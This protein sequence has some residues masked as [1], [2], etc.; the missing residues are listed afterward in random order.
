MSTFSLLRV[1]VGGSQEAASGVWS[2]LALLGSMTALCRHHGG[3]VTG[4]RE[5]GWG[6]EA[7]GSAATSGQCWGIVAACESFRAYK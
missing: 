5:A 4:P 7:A 2:Q 6:V 3:V 1:D